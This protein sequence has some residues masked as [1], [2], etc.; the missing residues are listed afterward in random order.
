MNKNNFNCLQTRFFFS[1]P[2][3]LIDLFQ[4]IYQMK[5]ARLDLM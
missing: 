3:K 1:N 5:Q 4:I 2:T